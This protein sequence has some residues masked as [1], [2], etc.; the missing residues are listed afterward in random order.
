[1][2][3]GALVHPKRSIKGEG[4]R[5]PLG[6]L[7][8]VTH[9]N[10]DWSVV[11]GFGEEWSRFQQDQ[12]TESEYLRSFN[13]YFHI[14]PWHLLGPISRGADI[15]CGSGRW[16]KLAAP[17][18]GKLYAIDPSK[19]ALAVA[20]KN[21][22]G[23][24]NVEYVNAAVHELPF[25]D[26]ELDFAYSLGVLH[27]VPDTEAAIGQVARVL[28]PGAPFL[29]Y[30][31]YRFDNRSRLF[32]TIWQ[33][34]DILRRGISQLQPDWKHLACDVIASLVYWPLTR[35]ALLAEKLG[36][37][38]HGIPL[39]Y[40]RSS[41]FYTMRTDAL[42]RFGTRL[43]HRFTRTEIEGMLQRSGF[44]KPVFSQQEPYWCALAYR[45]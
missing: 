22:A 14:F 19:A 40:H 3:T 27:H 23:I 13:D 6:N 35:I 12:M 36:I 39:S 18:T 45:I 25:G 38:P 37:D 43:E 30:L 9:A 4:N 5:P 42:D 41:S 28:K 7:R 33:I 2:F 29:I 10:I 15:G 24:A 26:G 20:Q 1:M 8:T 17:K 34:T 31:Y 11:D 21:C 44:S 32:R 16:A